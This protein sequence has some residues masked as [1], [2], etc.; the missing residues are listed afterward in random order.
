MRGWG[1]AATARVVDNPINMPDESASARSRKRF[2]QLYAP[3]VGQ[4]A[5]NLLM[6]QDV[7]SLKPG[8]WFDPFGGNAPLWSL[9]YEWWFYMMFFVLATRLQRSASSQKY[10]VFALSLTGCAIYQRFPNQLCLFLGYFLTWWAGAECA[11]EYVDRGAVTWRR[12]SPTVL[13]LGL[14]CVA[15]TTGIVVAHHHGVHLRWGTAPILQ[16]RHVGAALLLLTAGITWYKLRFPGFR[17]TFGPLAALG[18]VSYALYVLHYPVLAY[19]SAVTHVSSIA[20]LL[21]AMALVLPLAYLLEVRAQPRINA[22]FSG[23]SSGRT[24]RVQP[25]QGEPLTAVMDSGTP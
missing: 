1:A 5:G 8:V 6:L 4:L 25:P 21:L 3:A 22:W 2:V 23:L 16:V 15:W 12:Q 11:R 10:V 7:S 24:R 14:L 17:F 13:M 19:L 9:S 20:R 18:P